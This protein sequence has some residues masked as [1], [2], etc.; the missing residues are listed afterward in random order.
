V[1]DTK[2]IHPPE[3]PLKILRFFLKEKYLEEIEGDLEELFHENVERFSLRSKAHVHLGRAE[4]AEAR[5]GE[6]S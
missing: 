2:D 3:W 5:A 1:R 4:V 6:E